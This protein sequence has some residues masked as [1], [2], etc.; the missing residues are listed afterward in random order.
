MMGV[1]VVTP[2]LFGSIA[3]EHPTG[4]SWRVTKKGRLVVQ[5]ADAR[6]VARYKDSRWLEV[7][8]YDGRQIAERGTDDA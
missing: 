6:E 1:R 3:R 5:D 4:V 8:S 7:W 2:G